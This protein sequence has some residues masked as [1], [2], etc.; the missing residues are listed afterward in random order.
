MNSWND[1]VSYFS[2]EPLDPDQSY[3]FFKTMNIKF[4][5]TINQ[6]GSEWFCNTTYSLLTDGTF[7][8]L[9]L[10]LGI[11]LEAGQ[12]IDIAVVTPS[13][14]LPTS[15]QIFQFKCVWNSI[16]KKMLIE[17]VLKRRERIC[18]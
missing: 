4:G 15:K 18:A 17:S 6:E 13:C 2:T 14:F 11:S 3:F 12:I 10:L 8:F 5:I 16:E 9:L 1:I 7:H